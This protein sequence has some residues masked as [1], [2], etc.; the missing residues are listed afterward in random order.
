MQLKYGKDTISLM[1]DTGVAWN[2]LPEQI[3]GDFSVSGP[4]LVK[5]AVADLVN[6][7][8][9][10]P[11]PS[12]PRLLLI[13]PDHTRRCRLEEILAGLLPALEKK[14]DADIRILVANGSHV[15]QPEALLREVVGEAVC[16]R[17]AVLQ[18]D[19]LD[20]VQLAD[21]GTTTFGTP[22]RLNRLVIESDFVITIGAI[23]YHYFA[24]FGG[25]PKM[26]LPGVAGLESIRINHRRTLDP[27]SGLFHHD[28]QEGNIVTNP[29]FIDLAQ[30]VHFV[31]HALSLQ[32]VLSP[33]GE[34][35]EAAAGPILPIHRRL[36]ERVR[37]IYAL[38]IDDRADVVIA[39]AGGYPADVNLIQSHK[40][41][42][43]ACQAL[44]PAGTLIVLAECAQ[45]IGSSYFMRYFTGATSCEMGLQLLRDY[46]INGHTA[47]ALRRKTETARII[48]VSGLDA[49]AVRQTGMHAAASFAE[50]WAMTAPHL[51]AGA[52]GYIL[53]DSSK[54]VPIQR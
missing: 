14:Y 49:D 25:G 37:Q 28:C 21:L 19:A 32:V 22:V 36:T 18:H 3:P 54:F 6:Q 48:L 9:A 7:L 20:D 24:G 23:L 44:K 51:P 47:L 53:P 2:V 38:P 5:E 17:H 52:R 31:P 35:V 27:V 4:R 26:L 13:V 12:R 42:H 50:A 46:Q 11:I 33:Q 10:F 16:A 34:I 15:L 1:P 30:V 40:S 29:V 41:I 8:D 39:S 43:H 45:G